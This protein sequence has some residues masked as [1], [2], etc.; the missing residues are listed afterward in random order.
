MPMEKNNISGLYQ[1]LDSLFEQDVDSDTL[2]ASSYVRGFISLAASDQGDEQQM[3]TA[4]LVD[5]ISDKLAKAKIELS[6]QDQVIVQ[7]F[8]L[9]LQQKIDCVS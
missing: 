7:N 6:P 3:I 5:S 4:L 2:F 1:Y 9:S 8:W